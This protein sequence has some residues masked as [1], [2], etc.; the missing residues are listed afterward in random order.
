MQVEIPCVSCGGVACR[1]QAPELGPAERLLSERAIAM[2]V[3][4]AGDMTGA[5]FG[6]SQAQLS[7]AMRVTCL[8]CVDREVLTLVEGAGTGAS[9]L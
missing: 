4:G 7:V 6:L 1:I 2:F 8:D 9:E 5:L 3:P